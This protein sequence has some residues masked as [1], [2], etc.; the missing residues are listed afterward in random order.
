MFIY[1]PRIRQYLLSKI[2]KISIEI[3]F[4]IHENSIYALNNIWTP[5][6]L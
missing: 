2:Y 1:Q 4:K 6:D 3:S 5:R